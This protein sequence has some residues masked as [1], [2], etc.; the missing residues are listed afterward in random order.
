MPCTS[1]VHV[2]VVSEHSSESD[3]FN[4]KIAKRLGLVSS[5]I[6]NLVQSAPLRHFS[7]QTAFFS[8][9]LPQLHQVLFDWLY[10]SITSSSVQDN[11]L[12]VKGVTITEGE[13]LSHPNDENAALPAIAFN[14]AQGRHL[15]VWSVINLNVAERTSGDK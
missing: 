4:P 2:L 15:S 3:A 7:A 14:P 6:W 5:P 10:K 12:S 9:V 11:S 1:H 8:G 13:P